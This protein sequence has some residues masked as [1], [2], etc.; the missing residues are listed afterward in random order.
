[1]VTVNFFN[2]LE[3][4]HTLK[5]GL[6]FVWRKNKIKSEDHVSML[7]RTK[8]EGPMD[9]MREVKFIALIFPLI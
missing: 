6:F 1:M 5:L 4:D 8:K 2:G 9:K 7:G 3:V